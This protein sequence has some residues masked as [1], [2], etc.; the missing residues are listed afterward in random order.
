MPEDPHRWRGDQCAD[1][2][3]GKRTFLCLPLV[4]LQD[5]GTS[6]SFNIIC[7]PRRRWSL[8][9]V[10]DLNF[11]TIEDTDGS[12]PDVL[13][14]ELEDKQDQVSEELRLQT[15]SGAWS[16]VMGLYYLEEDHRAVTDLNFNAVGRV[17]HFDS[18]NET[19]AYAAFSQVT[20]AFTPHLNGTVGL[21]IQL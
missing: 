16:T 4:D 5:R 18:S 9:P 15:V 11:H 19:S 17:S 14:T 8:L 12:N 2:S 7:L 20:Y 10:I 6:G 13:V 1:R 21:A 3:L